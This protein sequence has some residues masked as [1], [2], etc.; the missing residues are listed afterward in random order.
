MNASIYLYQQHLQLQNA[1]FALI[2]HEDTTVAIV[3]KITQ[4]NGTELILKICTRANDYLRE[5]YFLKCLAGIIPVPRIIQVVSP[6]TSVHGAILMECLKGTL[7]NPLDL[8][9]AL[10]Y[11]IGSA[12]ALLHSNRVGPHSTS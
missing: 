9:N 6:E 7:L 12:L 3:Y 5:V 1:T 8:T 10:A 2:D 11:E 4:F